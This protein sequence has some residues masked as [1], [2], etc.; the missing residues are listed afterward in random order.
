VI[1][2]VTSRSVSIGSTTS[3]TAACTAA[4]A[5]PGAATSARRSIAWAAQSTSTARIVATFSSTSTALRAA[6]QPIETWSSWLPLVGMLSTPAGWA[7]TR[8]S[9][10]SDAA[11]YWASMKPELVP[12]ARARNGGSPRE[13]A[14]SSIR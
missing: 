13:V 2:P 5:G 12:A 14:G 4:A 9:A 1:W 11:V 7:S 3:R 10:T 8:S 6:C